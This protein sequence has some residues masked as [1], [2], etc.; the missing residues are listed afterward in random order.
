MSETPRSRRARA[1]ALLE[2]SGLGALLRRLP[3][4]RGVVVL[5]YHRVGDPRATLLDRGVFSATEADFDAQLGILARSFE[6]IGLDEL[7]AAAERPRGRALMLTFDDGYRDQAAPAAQLLHARGLPA[8]FFLTTGF[9][10]GSGLSWWDEIAW[11]VRTSGEPGLR[12]DGRFELSDVAFDEPERELA[13]RT[14]LERFRQLPGEEYGAFLDFVGERLSTGR[15]AGGAGPWMSWD[16]ARTLERLGHRVGGHSVSHPI[17]A[18]LA[19]DAQREEVRGCLERLRAELTHPVDSFAYPSGHLGSFDA[20][21][22]ELLR[23]HGVRYAF[24]FR[25]GWQRPG[26]VEPYD[27][28]RIGVFADHP[29]PLVAATVSLPFALAREAG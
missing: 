21:T 10:D 28:C 7:E 3:L 22:A 24:S 17:L 5:G 26:Q 23:E 9:L 11:M 14:L 1:A 25:G 6:V 8:T 16:D 19:G 13:V 27:V 20:G 4:W 29:T 12:S 18:R 15:A 2:R